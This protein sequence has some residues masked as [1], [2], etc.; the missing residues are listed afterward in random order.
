[1]QNQI[2]ETLHLYFDNVVT[3]I[4][5]KINSNIYKE[6]KKV[7]GYRPEDAVFRQKQIFHSQGWHWDGY[8][9]TLC[10]NR[11]YCKCALPKD[12]THFPTGLLSKA[13]KFL[14]ENNYEY[15]YYG[16]DL[17]E[18]MIKSAIEN[19]INIVVRLS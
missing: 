17:S 8:E 12:G 6:L 15:N 13:V 4:E 2:T 14:K 9:T 19:C 11:H 10:R 3:T 7:L 5:G 16:Y 18:D 1:M